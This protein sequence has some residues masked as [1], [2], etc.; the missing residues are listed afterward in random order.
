MDVGYVEITADL[1]LKISRSLNILYHLI[2]NLLQNNSKSGIQA[3]I[4]SEFIAK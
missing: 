4:Y 1:C 2:P 3:S